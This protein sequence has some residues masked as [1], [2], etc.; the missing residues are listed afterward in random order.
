[1][2]DRVV[3]IGGPTASG[4]SRLALALAEE[5]GGVVIN[6][7]SMQLY[8][9]LAVLTARPGAA[10]TARAPHRL[11]GI[12]PAA[13]ACSAARWR[14]LA[15]A[16]IAQARE[17]GRLP[18]LVGGTGLYFRALLKGLAPVPPVPA[19]VRLKARALFERLGG[20]AFRA[21]LA[22]RDPEMAAR[23]APND[24]QRLV[25]AFE[26][27]EATGRSLAS[28]Q[29]AAPAGAALA[30]GTLALRLE[31]PR[32]A[33]YAAC[34]ARFDAMLEQGA[35]D[36]ARRIA[37]LGLDPGLPAMKAVGLRELLA[38]LAGGLDFETARAK[39]K[40]ATRRYAKRQLTWFRHQWPEA[41]VFSAPYG[42]AT[43][44]QALRLL[45][46]SG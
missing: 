34:D 16:A 31:P 22:K 24:C 7:D 35:L 10:E 17:A 43:G 39:A 9:E 42:P 36:E 8:R 26:V 45:R 15:L 28:W 41:H 4:K 5:F 27:L 19:T 6:A 2:T 30:L 32:A 21:Q 18:I 37:A 44:A 14:T 33:L 1:M 38:H 12:V 13:E 46:R 25:R 3:L 23:L 20:P 29:R 11:Y 40:Q